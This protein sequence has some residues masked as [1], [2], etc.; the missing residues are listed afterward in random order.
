LCPSFGGAAVQ[1]SSRP[2]LSDRRAEQLLPLVDF[3]GVNLYPAW[4]W[5]RADANNQPIGVSPE[6]GFESFSATYH[7][8]KLKYPGRHIVV[9]ETGWPT[10]FG[11]IGSHQS[12]VG[13]SNARDY[14][15]RVIAWAR[16]QQV[17][18]YIHN[19]FDDHFGVDSTSPFNHHFGEIDNTGKPKGILF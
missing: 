11:P 15:R 14:L 5:Q 16:A 6:K 10:T 12:P 1:Q 19:M 13:I 9:T 8:I 4:D 2:W 7:Q 3:I 18:L 17:V